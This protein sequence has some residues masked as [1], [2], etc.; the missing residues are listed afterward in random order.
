L[1]KSAF[2]G[3]ASALLFP[4]DWPEPFGLVLIEAMACGTPAIAWRYGSVAEIIADGKTGF[5]V[6]TA[7][8]RGGH[9]SLTARALVMAACAT[10]DTPH[11]P[12]FRPS[13]WGL[14]VLGTFAVLALQRHVK[15]LEQAVGAKWLGEEAARTCLQDTRTNPLLGKSGNE[16]DGHAVTGRI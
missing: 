9:A 15:T 14:L 12:R 13:G 8:Q 3:N 11:E 10:C 7:A 6:D 5:I 4:I 2:L 16:D 1:E